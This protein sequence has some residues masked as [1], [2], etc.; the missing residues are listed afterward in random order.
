MTASVVQCLVCVVSPPKGVLFAIQR[1]QAG[2]LVPFAQQPD[3]LWFAFS[4][5]VGPR[6][7]GG[8]FNYRGEFAHGPSA[9]RFVYI[10]AGRLAGQPDSCWERRAKLKLASAPALMVQAVVDRDD[11]AIQATVLGTTADGGPVCAALRPAA[12]RWTV[13]RR[14]A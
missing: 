7:A 1:A 2:L 11:L 14:A 10:N 9:D 12:V 6:L 3:A 5:Y 8:A 4:L 13:A